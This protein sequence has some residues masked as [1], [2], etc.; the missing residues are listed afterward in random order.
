M[1]KQ[2]KFWQIL[3][4]IGKNDNLVIITSEINGFN[5]I[6]YVNFGKQTTDPYSFYTLDKIKNKKLWW[7]MDCRL[8]HFSIVLRDSLLE[9]L[10][11]NFRSMYFD[12]FS[13]NIYRHDY[14]K[15]CQVTECD[16]QILYKNIMILSDIKTTNKMIKNIILKDCNYEKTN[17]DVFNIKTDDPFKNTDTI[18]SLNISEKEI[19]E[20]L[21]DRN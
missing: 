15:Q 8:E 4:K 9:F 18:S 13:D 5:N 16:M 17:R 10:I 6:I 21:F 3:R 7:V 1:K 20:R 19:Q 12:I 2:K 14:K 11:N